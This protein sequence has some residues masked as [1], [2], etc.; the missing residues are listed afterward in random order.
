MAIPVTRT[1]KNAETFP[2]LNVSEVLFFSVWT[3]PSLNAYELLLIDA[4]W[5]ERP[6]YF[7]L[8]LNKL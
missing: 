8:N 1:Q 5:I 7:Y 3:F 2:S 6:N 4:Q